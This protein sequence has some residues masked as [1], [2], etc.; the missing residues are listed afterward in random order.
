MPPM[1]QASIA[2]QHTWAAFST[3][4]ITILIIMKGEIYMNDFLKPVMQIRIQKTINNLIK[5]NMNACCVKNSNEAMLKAKEFL[6]DGQLVAW[7][8]SATLKETGIVDMLKNGEYEYYDRTVSGLSPQQNKDYSRKA[9]LADVYFTGTNAITEDGEL[10]NVDG[11]C[12]RVAPLLYGPDKVVVVVGTNKIVANLEQAKLRVQK[13]TAPANGIRLNSNTPCVHLGECVGGLG[14]H[15]EN[16]LCCAYVTIGF[17][18]EKN[19][20]NVIFVED[21]LGF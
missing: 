14:C 8:G 4:H 10:Y 17:Q 6:Q 20:I 7:G 1:Q 9:F 13:L 11:N 16:R 19:R 2:N 18:R 5:N 21:D 15:S 3:I 12:N